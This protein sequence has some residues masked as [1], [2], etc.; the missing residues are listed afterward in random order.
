M[1]FNCVDLRSQKA[2]ALIEVMLALLLFSVGI[3]AVAS[4]QVTGFRITQLARTSMIDTFAVSEQLELL[5]A[6]PSEHAWLIDSD[7]GY[8][9]HKPDHG[10]FYLYHS[11][12]SIEWEVGAALPVPN[13]K[14][15]A[16]TL[17]R[18]HSGGH[19]RKLTYNSLKTEPYEIYA[20]Q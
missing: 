1:M 10:P 12:A 15:I 16:V 19:S 9:P 6:M 20:K 5:Y 3:L 17:H 18:A 11:P 8:Q 14:R 2:M 13:A 7:D 4:L